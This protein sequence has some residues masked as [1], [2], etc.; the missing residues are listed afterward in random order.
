MTD[1][2]NDA[3]LAAAFDASRAHLHAVAH[4]MLGSAAEADDAVQEAW[5]RVARA[6]THEVDNLRGWLTT[7]TARVCLD[8]L[9]TR[10]ARAKKE[11]AAGL[12]PGGELPSPMRHAESEAVLAESLGL[13]LLVVL[14]TLEPAE[15]IAFVLHDLF[16]VAFEEIAQIVER[17]PEAARQLASRARRRVRGAPERDDAALARQR[18]VVEALLRALRAGDV[19]GVVAVLDPNVVVRAE[20]PSGKINEVHGARAWAKSAAGFARSVGPEAMAKTVPALVDGAVGAIFAPDGKLAR[21]MKLTFANDD[22]IARLEIIGERMGLD[23]VE[24]GVLPSR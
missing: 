16:G 24:L 9:R 22:R 5:L 7:V 6:D 19:E 13:A 12:A 15:R 1:E 21:V 11:D 20:A 2:K 18:V 4:R 8:H 17:S 14:D 3:G 10:K 23:A